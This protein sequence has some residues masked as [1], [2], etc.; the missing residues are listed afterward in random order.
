MFC[1]ICGES[2]SS[3]HILEEC[4]GLEVERAL[5]CRDLPNGKISDLGWLARYGERPLNRF[6]LAVQAR[7]VAVGGMDI[8]SGHVEVLPDAD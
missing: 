8:R 4:K 3:Q 6:L 2:L 1:P 5:L 7:F